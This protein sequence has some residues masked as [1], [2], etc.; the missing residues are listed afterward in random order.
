MESLSEAGYKFAIFVGDS[1]AREAA[2]SLHRLAES[3]L[4]GCQPW[5]SSKGNI[6][7]KSDPS[8]QCD[9]ASFSSCR[10]GSGTM[11][12]TNSIP[13]SCCEKAF[14]LF[15]HDDNL[16]SLENIMN[17]LN[18]KCQCK[19]IVYLQAGLH[20]MLESPSGSITYGS[21]SGRQDHTTNSLSMLLSRNL[22]NHTIVWASPPKLDFAIMELAPPKPDREQF[23][24]SG[25]LLWKDMDLSA[26]K[27]INSPNVV[28]SEQFEVS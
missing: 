5:T 3:D 14:S 21:F 12:H 27:S 6:D 16:Q 15:R 2:W 8:F 17:V 25:S 18:T 20:P 4:T 10:G 7:T 11:G 1:I 19:G 9:G 28:Y 22:M 26:I 23:P 24:V 13:S